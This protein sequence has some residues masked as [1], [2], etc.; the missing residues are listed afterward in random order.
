MSGLGTPSFLVGR[1]AKGQGLRVS[2]PFFDGTQMSNLFSR[3]REVIQRYAAEIA[4]ESREAAPVATGDLR[5][6]I[7]V[8]WKEI[9]KSRDDKVVRLIAIVASPL[10]YAPFVESGRKPGRAPP[11]AEL[12]RW[13]RAKGLR[14]SPVWAQGRASKTMSG[15]AQYA[16]LLQKKIRMFGVKPNPYMKPAISRSRD[17]F[18]D[19]LGAVVSREMRS[20]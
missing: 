11:R 3:G 5:N 9:K 8:T 16:I 7:G 13:I 1:G 4:N 12:E 10:R 18:V 6:S 19:E 15:E 14:Y 2:G 20:A 17:P